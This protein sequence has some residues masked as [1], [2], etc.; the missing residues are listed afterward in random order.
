MMRSM[1]TTKIRDIEELA[2]ELAHVRRGRTVVHCHGVFD[3][4]HIGHIRHFQ[5]ARK[6]GNLL[7]VTVTPD[8]YVN[9]GPHRPVFTA[10][11]R[12]EAIASLD[13][14]DYVAINKW[15]TA[16]EAIELLRPDVYAKGSDY[17]DAATDHTGGITLERN[18]V[19]R[20]G[21]RL[22]FTDE[23]TFSSS[24]LLNQHMS[25][26]SPDV[27]SY[28]EAFRGK[29]SVSDVTGYI[30]RAQSLRVLVIGEAIIDEYQYCDTLGKSGK[31]PILAAQ[32][33][34]SEKFIGGSLA[35]A[36]HVASC[37]PNV[38][39]ATMIGTEDSHEVFIRGGLSPEVTP[40][41]LRMENAPT[42]VKRRFIE[43]YPFQKLF[44]IYVMDEG[45]AQRKSPELRAVLERL[46][47]EVDLVVVADYGH[48]MIGPSAV[49]VLCDKARCLAINTQVNAGNHGFNTVS[50]YRKADFVCLSEKEIRL[51]TRNPTGDLH[52]IVER[53]SR[54][55]SCSRLLVTRGA[56]GSLCYSADEGF[57]DTP[58]FALRTV[59]R[60]GA[61]DAVFAIGSICVALGAPIEVIGF[62]GNAVGSEAVGIVG[63]QRFIERA[64]LL[65]HVEALL[66]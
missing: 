42:L 1:V 30:T 15:P 16:V 6:E 33:V 19:E 44:E 2:I 7:I 49:D 65:K 31:E 26:F 13:G 52:E 63:N 57:F 47:P 12:A 35:V 48:G 25:I 24:T 32:F 43:S 40:E 41:L 18:A 61:G 54:D 9:K 36:N 11:L 53:V 4:L 17:A 60:V 8:H 62:I 38:R 5:Q 10:A 34:R 58:A 46:V 21:G 56:K 55:L 64:P 59:D 3:L 14:V 39:L 50:K 27:R 23:I 37:T 22:A 66:K 29:F 20:V 45:A 51:E 28:L